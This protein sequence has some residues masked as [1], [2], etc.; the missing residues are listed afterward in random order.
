MISI[1]IQTR[2]CL[3]IVILPLF[4]TVFLIINSCQ[5]SVEEKI[6]SP[7][8]WREVSNNV[9]Q[10]NDLERLRSEVPFDVIIPRYIPD[11]TDLSMPDFQL[12]YDEDGGIHLLAMYFDLVH[13]QDII[14]KQ[15]PLTNPESYYKTY[16]M[17]GYEIISL[18][19]TEVLEKCFKGQ[20]LSNQP[21]DT[22]KYLWPMEEI[23]CRV[24]L[25]GFTQ[26]EARK[27]VESMIKH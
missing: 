10:T 14:I 24:D 2:N 9:I 12:K 23:Q 27:I 15:L 13:Y 7:L 1:V 17:N 11:E 20:T 4:F 22:Y 8:F 16:Q 25:G 18:G 26:E 5:T 21:G 3:K 6:D 19:S